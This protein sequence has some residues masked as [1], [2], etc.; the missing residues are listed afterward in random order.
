MPTFSDSLLVTKIL[1][2]I[3]VVHDDMFI[4]LVKEDRALG[5]FFA[6]INLC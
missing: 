3:L 4:L 6:F 2:P 5:S 1:H